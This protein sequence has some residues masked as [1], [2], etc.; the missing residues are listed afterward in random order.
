MADLSPRRPV[1]SLAVPRDAIIYLKAHEGLRLFPYDDATGRNAGPGEPLIGVL[2]IGYGHT[3]AAAREWGG[4]TGERATAL[5]ETDVERVAVAPIRRLV[6]APLDPS[7]FGALV[8][9]V[10][11]IGAGAFSR[12]TLLRKVNA[13]DYA[14]AG[15]EFGRWTKQ[16]RGNRL[17]EMPGLVKRRAAERAMWEGDFSWEIETPSPSQRVPHGTPVVPPETWAGRLWNLLDLETKRWMT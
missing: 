5:F 3:G 11:N 17:V 16:R 12:S 4:I 8:M 2:T 9:F 14:G 15:L 1:G 6:R 13:R 10:F 7:E